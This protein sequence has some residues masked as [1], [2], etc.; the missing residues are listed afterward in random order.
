MDDYRSL[1]QWNVQSSRPYGSTKTAHKWRSF[2]K[3]LRENEITSSYIRMDIKVR[4]NLLKTPGIKNDK[5]KIK[6]SRTKN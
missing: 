2:K 6:P 5:T 1:V 4:R 3:V